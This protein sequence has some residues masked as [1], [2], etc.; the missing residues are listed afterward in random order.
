[1]WLETC[2]WW[3]PR[4]LQYWPRTRLRGLF[5]RVS[6][7]SRRDLWCRRWLMPN[8]LGRI[9]K[10]S[11]S[12]WSESSSAFIFCF[13]ICSVNHHNVSSSSCAEGS[14]ITSVIR[15]YVSTLQRSCSRWKP[16][17]T[18][19][20][21][22]KKTYSGSNQSS[23]RISKKKSKK[24]CSEYKTAFKIQQTQQTINYESW[25]ATKEILA[26]T[27]FR[28]INI[29]QFISSGKCIAFKS[30]LQLSPDLV[31]FLGIDTLSLWFDGK[32]N[33][34]SPFESE[35]WSDTKIFQF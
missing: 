2:P 16:L 12:F 1:M 5:G 34:P 21:R 10:I 30:K 28:L 27:F 8:F 29:N 25:V 19:K 17:G 15:T 7:E 33:T 20:Q 24:F 11:K 23:K 22:Q 13:T 3:G 14:R 6:L 35:V 9:C 4:Y 31:K 18:S 26:F 32:F